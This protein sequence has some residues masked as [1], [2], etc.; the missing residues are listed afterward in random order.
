MI[1]E[2]LL[3]FIL[4]GITISLFGL[5]IAKESVLALKVKVFLRLTQPYN[6]KLS[7]FSQFKFWRKLIGTAFYFVFPL[8]LIVV[9]LFRL[10]RFI[11]E[12]LDCEYC[13][14]VWY[15]FICIT[16]FIWILCIRQEFYISIIFYVFNINSIYSKVIMFFIERFI[17]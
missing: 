10:H 14:S 1:I 12:L 3:L 11:S 17:F 16:S 9:L 13:Q 6:K 8:I 15:I 2:S 5:Q 4:L 7:A